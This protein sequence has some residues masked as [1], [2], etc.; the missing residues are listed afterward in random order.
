MIIID[1]LDGVYKKIKKLFKAKKHKD[2]SNLEHFPQVGDCILIEGEGLVADGIEWMEGGEVSH[3]A[4]Y[5]GGGEAKIIEALSNGVKIQKL[6]KYFKDDYRIVIRRIPGLEVAEAEEMKA[7][8]Y[9]QVDKPYD[10]NQFVSLGFYFILNK[11][12]ID[13]LLRNWFH[14]EVDNNVDDNENAIICSELYA[15][16]AKEAGYNLCGKKNMSLI[17]P[18]DLLK[19]TRMETVIEV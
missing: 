6:D 2:F 1:F 8:A 15:R 14:Y 9:S 5:V 19:S 16:A 3:T 13:D 12:G 4:L 18:Q 7:Y 17:T 11:L 10:F